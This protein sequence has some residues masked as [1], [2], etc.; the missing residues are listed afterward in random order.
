[1]VNLTVCEVSS[2]HRGIAEA[3]P[4]V[5]CDAAL[6]CSYRRFGTPFRPCVLVKQ[7]KK[8]LGTDRLPTPSAT[9][10]MGFGTT[11]GGGGWLMFFVGLFYEVKTPSVRDIGTS[12]KSSVGF[13]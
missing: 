9:A 4:V 5:E 12:A 2:F 11:V 10:N 8:D 1:M 3:L 6:V 7:Y 13:S